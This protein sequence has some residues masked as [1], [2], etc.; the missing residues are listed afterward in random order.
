MARAGDIWKKGTTGQTGQT[1][2]GQFEN[3]ELPAELKFDWKRTRRELV[4]K[5]SGH[6]IRSRAK[7]AVVGLSGG[8][9]SSLAAFLV[10]EAIGSG[11][12]LGV[13]MPD[14]GTTSRKDAEDALKLANF[15][16]IRTRTVE[17]SQ[18]VRAV[19]SM[20]PEI[21]KKGGFPVP[22]AN[23][24]SRIRMVVLYAI[25]NSLGNARVIGTGDKSEFLLGYCTKYGD[26]GADVFVNGRLYKTQARY[27]AMKLRL[28]E[29]IWMRKPSPGLIKGFDAESELGLDYG[30]LDLVL[31]YFEK[32]NDAGKI[33]EKLKL[34]ER[35]VRNL[36]ERV[37]KNRH[38]REFPQVL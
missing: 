36:V 37:D 9:D 30:K 17:I 25:A 20:V 29:E 32:G 28:P 15:I 3:W 38:K 31:H 5:I 23:V 18:A 6:F 21:K 22:L 26:H 7:R 8:L 2:T 1:S 19:S 16:G 33:A 24:K 13:L 12:V 4:R 27:L 34:K 10:S 11:N 14:R 35:T